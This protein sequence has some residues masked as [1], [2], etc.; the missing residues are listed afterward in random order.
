MRESTRRAEKSTIYKGKFRKSAK[1]R[2]C[3]EKYRGSTR[4]GAAKKMQ[5]IS[6]NKKKLCA[7]AGFAFQPMVA[8][9]VGGA[10]GPAAVKVFTEL[11]KSKSILSGEPKDVLLTQ[12]YQNLGVILH[13]ENAR[14][15]VKR[16]CGSTRTSNSVLAAAATLQIPS[17]ED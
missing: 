2:R 9:A 16:R 6:G 15:I 3:G 7:E 1:T 8:E 13:R 10:W 17:A 14:S 11:A 4:G 12:L 5:F